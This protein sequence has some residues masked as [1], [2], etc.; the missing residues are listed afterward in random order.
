MEWYM[1]NTV[2]R[3][4]DPEAISQQTTASLGKVSLPQSGRPR[5]GEL[6]VVLYINM[7]V[8]VVLIQ[9]ANNE[10]TAPHAVW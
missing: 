4:R 7:Y 8:C 5:L 2:N 3:W 9:V 1:L 10:S 6:R